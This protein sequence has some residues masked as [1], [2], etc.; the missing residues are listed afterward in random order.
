MAN[1]LQRKPWSSLLIQS[2]REFTSEMQNMCSHREFEQSGS[3]KASHSGNR[4]RPLK[5][6]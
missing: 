5:E 6:R 1:E 3:A 2:V 4:I